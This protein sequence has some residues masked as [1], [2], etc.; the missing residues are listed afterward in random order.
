[1]FPENGYSRMEGFL[2]L[3]LGGKDRNKFLTSQLVFGN[4]KSIIESCISFPVLCNKL[5]ET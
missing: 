1:M 5:P 4:F 3:D 2:C